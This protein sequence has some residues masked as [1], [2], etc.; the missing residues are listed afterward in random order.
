MSNQRSVKDSFEASEL[1]STPPLTPDLQ[2]SLTYL[3]IMLWGA[4]WRWSGAQL[5]GGGQVE[6]FPTKEQQKWGASEVDGI[7]LCVSR[8][9]GATGTG[10]AG[11]PTPCPSTSATRPLRRQAPALLSHT[12]RQGQHKRRDTQWGASSGAV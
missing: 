3:P 10:L 4:G 11:C 1:I 2:A 6:A 9:E 7:S 12:P 5:E 8:S